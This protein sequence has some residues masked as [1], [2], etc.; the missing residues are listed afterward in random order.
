MTELFAGS[1]YKG[2]QGRIVRQMTCLAVWLLFWFGAWQLF[3]ILRSGFF[4]SVRGVPWVVYGLP[5]AFAAFGTW[6]GYRVVNWPK[7]AD[8]LISVESEMSKVS[9]PTKTELYRAAIVVIFTMAVLAVVLF[10]FDIF[11]QF[12]FEQ[13]RV[14]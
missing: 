3:E 14:S 9:W 8:F 5:I 1:I 4:E 13:L 11:W 7:F 12:V 6:F 2:R 10:A